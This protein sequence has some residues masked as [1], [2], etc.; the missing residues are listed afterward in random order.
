MTT[1]PTMCHSLVTPPAAAYAGLYLRL[2]KGA[3]FVLIA[4]P[5]CLPF[6][7]FHRALALRSFHSVAAHDL[8]R[9]FEPHRRINVPPNSI[10]DSQ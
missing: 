10:N 9:P 8:K 3:H 2:V 4:P 7:L 1:L 5:S 6:Y